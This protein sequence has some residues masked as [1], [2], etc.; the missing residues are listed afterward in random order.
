M[1][2]KSNF[3]LTNSGTEVAERLIQLG[4]APKKQLHGD[5]YIVS[6]MQG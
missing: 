3:G 2:K 6:G 5:G 4:L 1:G